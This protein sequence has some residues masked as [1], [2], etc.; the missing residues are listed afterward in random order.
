MS[1]RLRALFVVAGLAWTVAPSEADACSCAPPNHARDVRQYS[2]AFRGVARSA[3][4][5][6]GDIEVT[7]TVQ[8][9]WNGVSASTTEVRV[10]RARG[11]AMCPIPSF[12]I[13]ARYNVYAARVAGGQ[14]RVGGCNP[15]REL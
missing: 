14:L 12:R 7:F 11:L 10:L 9:R 5:V 15:S 13:G 4:R 8:T 1:T 6:G 2:V 3:R